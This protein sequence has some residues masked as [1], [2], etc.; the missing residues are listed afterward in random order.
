MPSAHTDTQ[1]NLCDDE[2]TFG[3]HVTSGPARQRVIPY[4][5]GRG[6]DSISTQVTSD[7]IL[8]Q[9]STAARAFAASRTGGGPCKRV[10]CS[11]GTRSAGRSTSL[12]HIG[13][14]RRTQTTHTHTHMHTSTQNNTSGS[15]HS[16]AIQP[17]RPSLGGIYYTSEN[18]TPLT[19]PSLE[20][21]L[22]HIHNSS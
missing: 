5:G 18:I 4:G 1:Q 15:A 10:R 21:Y 6:G 19:T 16:H 14:C 11:S 3:A 13:T 7:R 17:H 20:H 12:I 9:E 22:V 8:A 2:S